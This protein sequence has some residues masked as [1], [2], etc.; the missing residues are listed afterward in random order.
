MLSALDRI[1]RRAFTVF[2][3][4]EGE[5]FDERN[6]KDM[7]ITINLVIVLFYSAHLP[8]VVRTDSILSILLALSCYVVLLLPVVWCA[9]TRTLSLVATERFIC[10][11]GM[12]LTC[13]LH[14]ESYGTADTWAGAVVV[15]DLLLLIGAGEKVA[16]S[17]HNVVLVYLVFHAIISC[18]D[19]GIYGGLPPMST[20]EPPETQTVTAAVTFLAFRAFLLT[21]DFSMTKYFA[22]E[23]RKRE[24]QLESSVLA[25]H[26]VA[27]AMVDFDLD[28]ATQELERSDMDPSLQGAFN[29]LLVNLRTYR[30][31]LPD[32]L[33]RTDSVLP[34]MLSTR[35]PP[36]GDTIAIVFTDIQASTAIW[37]VFPSAMR[38]AMLVHDEVLRRAAC[39]CNGYE[40]KTIGDAFMVAFD[41][42]TEAVMFAFTSQEGLFNATWPDEVLEHPLCKKSTVWNGLRVRMGVHC[43]EG[44]EVQTNPVTGR[45][46]Y[47]GTVVNTASRIEGLAHGGVVAMS[48]DL[49]DAFTAANPSSARGIATSCLGSVALKGITGPTDVMLA[50]PAHL[51][52]RLTNFETTPMPLRERRDSMT[53]ISAISSHS[54]TLSEIEGRRM[55]CYHGSF[56]SVRVDYVSVGE[57]CAMPNTIVSVVDCSERTKGKILSVCSSFIVVAWNVGQSCTGHHINAARFAG[58]LRKQTLSSPWSPTT[59]VGICTGPVLHGLVGTGSQRF[60]LVIGQCVELAGAL[61]SAAVGLGAF[62]LAAAAPGNK[63]VADDPSMK[64]ATRMVDRWELENGTVAVHEVNVVWIRT[65]QFREGEEIFE[66]GWSRDYHKAFDDKDAVL[67][68]TMA[69]ADPVLQRVADS[70]S[71]APPQRTIPCNSHVSQFLSER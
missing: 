23:M 31:Y 39:S 32:A 26:S 42:L 36:R 5:D 64:A 33:F 15:I 61:S 54:G 43:G 3:Y 48:R 49:L 44:V 30:P 19:T 16:L 10:L 53:T 12:R 21:C 62:C 59:T 29:N 58:F 24:Q 6:R 46:D 60:V 66:W 45:A 11:G 27:L 67:I 55:H 8:L 35:P 47:Y 63:S 38:R 2:F 1:R 65:Q 51:K 13:M 41:N 14:F 70:L 20:A 9:V 57:S 7:L 50:V 52:D 18:V 17:F 34:A 71:R 25:A 22:L 40:V 28:L 4:R 69:S 37:D 56:A 68:R